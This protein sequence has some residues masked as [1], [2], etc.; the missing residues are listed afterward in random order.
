M[1][2]RTL[3][4]RVAI[5]AGC[6]TAFVGVAAPAAHAIP[7]SATATLECDPL[8]AGPWMTANWHIHLALDASAPYGYLFGIHADF[9]VGQ[10][11]YL[12]P[13][14]SLDVVEPGRDGLG[15]NLVVAADNFVLQKI[16]TTVCNPPQAETNFTCGKT[17]ADPSYLTYWMNN[18][19]PS[20]YNFVVHESNGLDITKQLTANTATVIENVNKGTHYHGWIE[21]NGVSWSG[22]EGDAICDAPP[23]TTSTSTT[24]TPPTTTPPTTAPP[25]T[26]PLVPDPTTT[27]PSTTPATTVAK[28][29]GSADRTTSTTT[30]IAAHA[31]AADP[32]TVAAPTGQLPFTGSSSMPLGAFA[33]VLVGAGS[34]LAFGLRRRSTV[35]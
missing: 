22:V 26:T 4:T 11:H 33:L 32:T 31:A 25:T 12:L 7:Q 23:T 17:A 28:A 8:P 13:G 29:G 10:N 34:A 21:L 27:T 15:S 18:P 14:E 16:G 5:I 20:T 2:V 30:A 3:L 9:N 19:S 35:R 1:P 6:A 24:T